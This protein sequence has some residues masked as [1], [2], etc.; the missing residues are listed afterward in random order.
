MREQHIRIGKSRE[1][2]LSLFLPFIIGFGGLF[3]SQE[4]VDSE[5]LRFITALLSIAFVDY[6][7]LSG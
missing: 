6:L 5:K 7:N 3:I 2:I 1:K 4:I